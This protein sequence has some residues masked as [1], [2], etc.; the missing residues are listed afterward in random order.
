MNAT[1]R[2]LVW[3]TLPLGGLLGGALGSWLGTRYAIWVAVSGEALTPIWLLAS[4][5]IS[6]PDLVISEPDLLISEPGLDISKP[7]LAPP[8]STDGGLVHE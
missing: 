5:L 8:D 3:G 1:M 4:P 2:F 7:G 6:E